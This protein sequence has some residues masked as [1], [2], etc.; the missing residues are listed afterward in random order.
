MEWTQ[1][2]SRTVFGTY[3][4]AHDLVCMNPVLDD[5]AV[6]AAVVDCVLYHELLHKKHGTRR[7][8]GRRH[9]HT[10]EFRAEERLHPAFEETKRVLRA[11]ARGSCD[12]AGPDG[13]AVPDDEEAALDAAPSPDDPIEE[14][15][16]PPSLRSAFVA[17][18]NDP[19]P[20]G[21]GRK[22]K[23]CHLV[24]DREAL[25]RGA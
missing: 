17:G 15:D 13:A 22:Y 2:L 18:R 11:L 12:A 14:A 1:S 25:P 10:P 5:P 19:C 9:A 24:A 8:G 3:V 16:A 21:S 7:A 23:R 20:C 4:A 6:P